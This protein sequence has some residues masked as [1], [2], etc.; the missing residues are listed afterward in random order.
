MLVDTDHSN[1]SPVALTPDLMSDIAAISRIQAIPMILEIVCRTTGMRFAAVAR[2]TED[3][4]IACSLLDQI[5]FGLKPGGEL[6]VDTTICHQIRS[7]GTAVV[8]S[9]VDTDATYAGHPTPQMYGFQS[10]ISVP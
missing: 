8:I 3:R 1:P 4:W 10:Y 6:K 5:N 9:H 7:T 2:V